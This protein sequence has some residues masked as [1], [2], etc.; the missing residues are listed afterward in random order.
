MT[1]KQPSFHGFPK[2]QRAFSPGQRTTRQS[3]QCRPRGT[4]EAMHLVLRSDRAKG[5]KSLL[6]YDALVRALITKI[7]RRHGVRIYRVVNA[8]NHLHITLKLS[9]QF[10]WRGFISGI[11]GGIARAVQRKRDVKSKCGFWNSRP[12]TRLISWGRDYNIVKD[13][14][15]LNQLEADGVVPPRWQMLRPERW[16]H[17]VLAFT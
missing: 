2:E 16:R 11:T 14:H 15:T 9:K 8:G 3:R 5:A 10:L 13:Y 6:K 1:R 12:F 4:K 17:V 7:A